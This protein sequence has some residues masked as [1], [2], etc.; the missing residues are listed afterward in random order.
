MLDGT[1]KVA[2][3]ECCVTLLASNSRLG[4]VNISLTFCLHDRL[5]G[6]LELGEDG[7]IT[8]LGE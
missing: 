3:F 2:R 1:C 6:R 7:S 5:F 8:V 4:R